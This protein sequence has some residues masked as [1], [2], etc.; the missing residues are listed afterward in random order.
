MPSLKPPDPGTPTNQCLTH[1][2]PQEYDSVVDTM[3]LSNNLIFG[4]PVVFDTNDDSI[5]EGSKVLLT[6]KVR[7]TRH[8]ARPTRGPHTSLVC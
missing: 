7:A 8:A 6:Y 4:L 3:R 5:N 2:A 1:C